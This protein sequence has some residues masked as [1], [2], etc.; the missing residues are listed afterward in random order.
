MSYP[1]KL[2]FIVVI[3]IMLGGCTFNRVENI[4]TNGVERTEIPELHMRILFNGD[5]IEPTLLEIVDGS[6]TASTVDN[7]NPGGFHL[8][9]TCSFFADDSGFLIEEKGQINLSRQ[10]LDAI[11]GLTEKVIENGPDREFEQM[12]V[13]GPMN[14][15]WMIIDGQI[16]WSLYLSNI[17]GARSHDAYDE[18]T[19][20][21]LLR[22]AYSLIELSPFP[23][24]GE[25][26]PLSTPRDFQE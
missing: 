3:L 23:V 6:L 8:N 2:V 21:Y 12:R 10:Q 22:L 7:F 4:E 14:Y 19:S 26:S 20:K 16:Y 9:L 17:D 24:G 15:V 25:R 18:Y 11:W 13:L 1:K 5:W